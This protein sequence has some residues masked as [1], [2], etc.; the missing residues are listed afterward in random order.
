MQLTKRLAATALAVLVPAA[1]ALAATTPSGVFQG[2]LTNAGNTK[3]AGQ[4]DTFQ[5]QATFAKGKLT[6]LYGR[7]NWIPYN[8]KLTT[9]TYCG[10]AN[11]YDSKGTAKITQKPAPKGF[12]WMFVVTSSQQG[13][14]WFTVTL[15]GNWVSSTKATTDVRFYEHNMPDKGHCDSGQLPLTLK[16]G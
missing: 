4:S 9:S 11:S 13:Y 1:A 10:A 3:Q 2:T 14:G 16:K 8:S 15:K 5:I 7:G 6:R 12:D